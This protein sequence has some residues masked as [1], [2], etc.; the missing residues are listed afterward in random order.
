ARHERFV[1]WLIAKNL[2]K[3]RLVGQ[4]F[5]PT[6]LRHVIPQRELVAVFVHLVNLGATRAAVKLVPEAKTFL[7]TP[8]HGQAVDELRHEVSR[9]FGLLGINWDR[10]SARG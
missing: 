9:G 6:K 1:A 5:E 4:T 7:D 2:R 8:P 10:R 3:A